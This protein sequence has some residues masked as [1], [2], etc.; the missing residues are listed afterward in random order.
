MKFFALAKEG[1]SSVALYAGGIALV[2]LLV[3]LGSLPLLYDAAQRTPGLELD[4]ENKAFI[5][6]YGTIRLFVGELFSFVIACIGFVLYLRFAHKRPLLRIFTA[7]QK[8]RWARF[9]GFGIF[10]LIFIS[11]F[12]FLELLLGGQL[13]ALKWQFDGAKFWPLLFWALL[14]IPF[15]IGLEELVFRVYAL[16]GLYLRTKSAW[17][18]LIISALLF[19]ILHIENPEIEALG[20][21]VLIYYFIAGLFLGLITVQDEGLE[22]A[23]SFH[24][25]NNLFGALV[26]SSSWQVFSLDSLFIDT[27]E[28]GSALAHLAIGFLLFGILYFLLSKKFKWKPLR[29]LR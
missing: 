20:Y 16:Q 24:L 11:F 28:P 1:R 27:R 2:L 23:L 17:L 29:A 3:I 14:L 12:T 26:I 5:E 10:L 8:F 4:I 7:A 25:F 21:G 18:S 9:W 15:Q 22:L 19:A 13:E 6:A